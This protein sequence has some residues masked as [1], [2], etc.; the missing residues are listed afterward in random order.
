MVELHKIAR[1]GVLLCKFIARVEI[2]PQYTL[3]FLFLPELQVCISPIIIVMPST[4]VKFFSSILAYGLVPLLIAAQS[5]VC[6]I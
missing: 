1:K 2:Q 3:F 5:N 6:F 4:G